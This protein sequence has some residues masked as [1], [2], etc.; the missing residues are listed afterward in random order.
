MTNEKNKSNNN[1]GSFD[2]AVRYANHFAQDD[3]SVGG[4][5]KQTTAK[6]EADP[7][8]MTNEKSSDKRR[9]FDFTSR[10]VRE[11]FRSG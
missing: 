4:N 11:M 6:T 7:Y 5:T 9:S 8:G 3:T 2:C 1:R 10:K